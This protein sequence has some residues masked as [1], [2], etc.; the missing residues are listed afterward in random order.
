[1]RVLVVEN[2]DNTYLG[3]LSAALAEPAASVALVRAHRGEALPQ[4]SRGFD[5]L[6]VLGGGQNALDDAGSPWF[7]ALLDLIR[8]FSERDRAVL[9]V[10]LGAQLIARSFGAKNLIGAAPE[11]GWHG[12]A[13]TE[14]GRRD[15][16]LRD[17]PPRF[18]GFQWHDDTFT[19]PE[20]ATRLAESPVAPNQAFRIGRA[21]YA[22]QFHVEADRGVVGEWNRVFADVLAARHPDWT[23]RHPDEAT[24]HGPA[25]DK[26]GLQIARAWVRTI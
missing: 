4:G 6:V 17:L 14:E 9:G 16:L 25:A 23:M 7:P 2:F 26:A 22:I 24:R 15:P 1:M 18:P 13:L 8:D 11:F 12:V 3:Q 10:C 21:T 20:A 5:G 19:L